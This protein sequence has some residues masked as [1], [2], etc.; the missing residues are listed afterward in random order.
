MDALGYKPC[1][2]DPDICLKA[3]N[4]DGIDY[5]SYILCYV[6]YIMVIHHYARPILDRIE[7]FMK[8]K[9]SSVGD[10]DIYLGAKLKKLQMDNDRSG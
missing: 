2:T 8:L 4:Q 1:L 10:P 5:Y 9:E 6:D 3:K 7:Q